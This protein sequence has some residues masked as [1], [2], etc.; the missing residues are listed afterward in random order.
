MEIEEGEQQDK[1]L[2]YFEAL[3]K[4]VGS[5][6]DTEGLGAMQM[7][8]LIIGSVDAINGE[9]GAEVPAFVIT[10]HELKQ[11][12]LY[13]MQERLDFDFDWF[14]YQSSG[15]SEWRWN[16]YIGRRLA[17]LHDILGVHAMNRLWEEACMAFRKGRSQLTDQDWRI[18]QEGTEE[19]QEAWRSEHIKV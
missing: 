10:R 9:N 12:A 3:Q 13:W 16:A 5:N 7:G 17:R 6:R 2:E 14:L 8:P 11:L 1:G 19:E 4:S 18:F 15:S